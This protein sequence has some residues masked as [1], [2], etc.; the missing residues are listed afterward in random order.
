MTLGLGLKLGATTVALSIVS[1]G[2]MVFA[3]HRF[4]LEVE[5]SQAVE[6][7]WASP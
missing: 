4:E 6:A 3:L 1:L 5:R 2:V 7:D